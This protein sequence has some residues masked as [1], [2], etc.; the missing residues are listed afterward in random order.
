MQWKMITLFHKL[1][2]L[3]RWVCSSLVWDGLD[4]FGTA[5][6]EAGMDFAKC[7]LN[8]VNRFP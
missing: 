6:E 3:A 1:G 7:F 4:D 8:Q 2:R 5:A